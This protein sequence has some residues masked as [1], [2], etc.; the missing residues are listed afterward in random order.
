MRTD[1]SIEEEE[2]ERHRRIM[3][4]IM[5]KGNQAQDDED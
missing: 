2:E 5:K 1:F 3:R 4:G